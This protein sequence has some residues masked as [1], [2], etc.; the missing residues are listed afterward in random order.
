MLKHIVFTFIGEDKPGLIQRLADVIS[1][2][3]GN[4]LESNMSQLA[5]K[6]AGI[7]LIAVDDSA[8][9]ELCASLQ[10]LKSE[11]LQI[12]TETTENATTAGLMEL[13][14]NIM[15]PDRPG[16]V[17]S[18]TQALKANNINVKDMESRI[19]SAAMSG[20]PMFESDVTIQVVDQVDIDALI[21]EFN[22]ISLALGIDIE[23][24]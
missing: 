12:V 16:I 3:N 4:W 21:V 17:K 9:D 24:V 18:V 2:H 11:G 14:I 10:A 6:F 20:D 22:E 13:K 7:V 19:T 15:G 8:S 5:G 1:R 23:L